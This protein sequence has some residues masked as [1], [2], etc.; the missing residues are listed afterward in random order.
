M[1]IEETMLVTH[2]KCLD[3]SV[4]AILFV[5]AGGNRKNIIFS[6][7][8]DAET[9]EILRNLNKNFGGPILFVDVS[10]SES[11][12]KEV[13]RDDIF[14]LDHHKS[15]IPLQKFSWC[16]IEK[17]NYR[18]GCKMFYDWLIDNRLYGKNSIVLKYKELVEIADDVDRWCWNIKE[19]ELIS[20]LFGVLGQN[21][22]IERFLKNPSIELDSCEMYVVDLEEKKRDEYIKQKKKD[23]QIFYK[24][25]GDK[26]YKVGFV[27]T[28]THQSRI[29]SE[30]C[31]DLDLDLDFVVLVG[32]KS[33]SFRSRKSGD[34]DVSKIAKLNGGGGHQSASG[35][36]LKSIFGKD[37]IELV[38]EKMRFE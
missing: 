19:S 29:G 2:S 9:D 13:I 16:E 4:S 5:A 22:L 7:P 25:I 21:L 26:T 32:L 12:A 24:K 20:S 28:N 33:L 31:N 34:F 38:F 27:S 10:V 15:A 36:P 3:G 23:L 8:N 6:D 37:M 35:S 18:C 11:A 14:I 17:E 1:N 30:F